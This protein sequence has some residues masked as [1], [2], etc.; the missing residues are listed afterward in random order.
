MG[1]AASVDGETAE[2]EIGREVVVIRLD[3]N[4]AKLNDYS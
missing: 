3:T 2:I 4:E 1:I